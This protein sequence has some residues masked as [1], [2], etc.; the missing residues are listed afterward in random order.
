MS[1]IHKE[2]NG[3][4]VVDLD[5]SIDLYSAPP[6]KKFLK[7]LLRNDNKKIIISLEK[8]TF[9]D[10]SGLGMLV[11]LFFECKQLEIG[12]KLANVSAEA[13]NVFRQTKMENNF[14]IYE[15]L[16]EALASFL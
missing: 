2:I 7:S 12:I 4:D 5:G 11:N 3:A 1:Y 16:E 9:L 14:E 13:K 10:S 8:V 6:V 15:S